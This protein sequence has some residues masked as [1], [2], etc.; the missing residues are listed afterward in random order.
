MMSTVRCPLRSITRNCIEYPQ[1]DVVPFVLFCYDRDDA[2][3]AD[4]NNN[5]TTPWPDE[6]MQDVHGGDDEA[7]DDD[8][9]GEAVRGD[10]Q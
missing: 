8:D 9:T 3:G 1:H 10:H 2:L 6:D 4:R 7:S 5:G